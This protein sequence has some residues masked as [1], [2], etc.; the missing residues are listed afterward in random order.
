MEKALPQVC[1]S[2]ISLGRIC[3][4]SDIPFEGEGDFQLKKKKKMGRTGELRTK[5]RDAEDGK[6]TQEKE[7]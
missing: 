3:Q 6:M 7:G 5:V 2:L 1:F 4:N